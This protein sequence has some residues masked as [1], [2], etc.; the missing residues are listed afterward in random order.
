M[1]TRQADRK[2]PTGRKAACYLPWPAASRGERRC[3]SAGLALEPA[4][5]PLRQPAPDPEPLVVLER[6]LQALGLD[7]TAAAHFLGFPGR[8]AL[9]GERRLRIGLRA[10]RAVLPVQAPGIVLADTK[11]AERDDLSHGAPPALHNPVGYPPYPPVSV[12]YTSEITRACLTPRQVGYVIM[13]GGFT[14]GDW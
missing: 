11:D 6:V 4:P 2:T 14:R 12:N 5:F 10:Q 8:A 9:L 7:L 1:A 3:R 13:T